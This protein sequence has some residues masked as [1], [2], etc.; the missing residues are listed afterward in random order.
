MALYTYIHGE[1]PVKI[2]GISSGQRIERVLKT[3]GESTLIKDLS[4]LK[5]Q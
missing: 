3:S 4:A 5:E 2:W 1:C